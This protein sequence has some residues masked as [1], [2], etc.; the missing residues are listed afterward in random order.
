[1]RSSERAVTFFALSLLASASVL[2]ASVPAGSTEEQPPSPGPAVEQPPHW[3][4][5]RLL[6]ALRA[7]TPIDPV[8][9]KGDPYVLWH[10]R[11][12]P[13]T[14]A[15]TVC[16]VRFDRDQTH[17]RLSTF[18]NTAAARTAGFAV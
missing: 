14:P 6:A 4:D 2:L 3:A 1:M 10:G 17:Y 15:D 9:V 8:V 7:K 18:A 13:H 5:A 12:L 11:E 16:G